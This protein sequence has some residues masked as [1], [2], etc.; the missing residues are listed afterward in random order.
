MTNEQK[1]KTPEER[2]RAFWRFCKGQEKKNGC[3]GCP[4]KGVPP[5]REKCALTWLA[6]EAEDEL[7]PCPFCGGKA[8]FHE[9]RGTFEVDGS[10]LPT[11]HYEV[12]CSM[13]FA[14]TSSVAG[15][16]KNIVIERWN[17]RAK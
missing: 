13:C 3:P 7:L 10:K 5:Y 6:L 11:V 4:T 17:R 12:Y 14:Q 8:K 16:D 15:G 2:M 1:Y 9:E